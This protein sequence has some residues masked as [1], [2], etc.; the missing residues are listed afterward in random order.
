M[1]PKCSATSR[2]PTRIHTALSFP[3][4]I[5]SSSFRPPRHKLPDVF[6]GGRRENRQECSSPPQSTTTL[7][8]SMTQRILVTGSNGLIGS[9]VCLYFG[10]RGFQVHGLDNN[11]RAIF[12]GP[13]GDTRWNQ[14]RLTSNLKD[15]QHH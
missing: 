10:G 2:R 7:S 13:A 15:F 14:K 5:A 4:K 6:A 8:E 11:Q 9:E 12:F 1:S 3:P